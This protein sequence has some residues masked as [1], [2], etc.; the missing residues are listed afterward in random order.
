[1]GKYFISNYSNQLRSCLFILSIYLAQLLS[2]E[3]LCASPRDS[4]NIA[5][6]GAYYKKGGISSRVGIGASPSKDVFRLF[7][8]PLLLY[9]ALSIVY[10][11]EVGK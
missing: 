1:M 4:S 8:V 10:S 2:V 9:R 5:I 7:K 3:V 6:V 11:E